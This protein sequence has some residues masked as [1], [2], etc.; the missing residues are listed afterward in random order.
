MRDLISALR[1]FETTEDIEMYKLPLEAQREMAPDIIWLR[2]QGYVATT[3]AANHPYP[4]SVWL[5]P[6]GMIKRFELLGI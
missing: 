2:E 3:T 6:E 5:L 1:R 4:L